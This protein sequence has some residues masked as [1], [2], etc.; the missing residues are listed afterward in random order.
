MGVLTESYKVICDTGSALIIIQG[1]KGAASEVAIAAS[2]R[3][4][5]IGE[6]CARYNGTAIIR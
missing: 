4:V 1:E 5:L 2:S 6:P 3:H